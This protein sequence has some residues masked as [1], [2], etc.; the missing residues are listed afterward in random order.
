MSL[1]R[2]LQAISTTLLPRR[3]RLATIFCLLLLVVLVTAFYH[4]WLLV[5]G[6]ITAGDQP[7]FTAAHL[8]DGIP[9]PSLWDSTLLTGAYNI[10]QAP[11]FPFYLVQGVLA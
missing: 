5:P 4:V 6:L 2:P 8:K 11:F 1:M 7:Y 10:L 3:P 9:F